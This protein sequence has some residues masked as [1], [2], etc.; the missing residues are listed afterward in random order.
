MMIKSEATNDEEL[1]S[2]QINMIFVCDS[3]E[4]GNIQFINSITDDTIDHYIPPCDLPSTSPFYN[5]GQPQLVSVNLNYTALA[6]PYIDPAHIASI[7]IPE[8][9][10]I[11]DGT[12]NCTMYIDTG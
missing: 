7:A 2:N 9:A 6:G 10:Q 5:P 12:F 4:D 3:S 11:F 8:G 1:D